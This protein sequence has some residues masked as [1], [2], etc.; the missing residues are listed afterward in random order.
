MPS[1]LRTDFNALAGLFYVVDTH[2]ELFKKV[3]KE[4]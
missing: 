3:V 2:F 4:A 1:D